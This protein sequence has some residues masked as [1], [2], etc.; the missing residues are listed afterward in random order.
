MDMLS[1][2]FLSHRTINSGQETLWEPQQL[3]VNSESVPTI[4][5]TCP[6]T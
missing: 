1:D 2:L 6:E 4:E 3:L 5:L